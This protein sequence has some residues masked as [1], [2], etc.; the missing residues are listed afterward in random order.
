M[1][2]SLNYDVTGLTHTK[3]KINGCFLGLFIEFDSNSFET[4]VLLL[5]MIHLLSRSCNSEDINEYNTLA[6]KRVI[7]FEPYIKILPR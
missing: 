7:L 6:L 1:L 4:L 3:R 2:S 5:C